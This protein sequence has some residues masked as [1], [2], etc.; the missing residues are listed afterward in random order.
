MSPNDHLLFNSPIVGYAHHQIVVSDAGVPCDYAFIEVNA[1]FEK[2]TGI[3]RDN[4]IGR[5]AREVIPGIEH[6]A[7]DWIAYYGAIALN[8]GEK[9]FEQYCEHLERWYRV[10][11]YS[12]E[13]NCFTTVF[14]DITESRLQFE[15]LEAFFSVNLDLLCI[16]DLDG[17]FIKTNT[18]WTRIL[19]YSTEELNRRKFLEFVHPDDIQATLDVMATLGQG[20]DVLDF[21]NRYRSSDGS[22]RYIQW[23]SHP[24]GNLVYAAARDITGSKQLEEAARDA[25]LRFSLAAKAGNVGVWDYDVAGNHLLWDEQMYALYGITS[26]TFSGVYE[27]WRSGLHPEDI[28]RGDREITMALKGEREFNTEFRV[29]WPDGSIHHIRALATVIRDPQGNAIRMVGTNWDI[30]Q[31]KTN[32][33]ALKRAKEEAETANKAK[34]VFLANM[35]HEIRTPLNSVIGFTDLLRKTAL[36]PMQ[37]QYADNANVSGRALLDIINDILDFS[38]IEAG[39]L[40]LELIRTDMVELLRNSINIVKLSA[41]QKQLDVLLDID[42]AMPQFA[43]VDPV[44]LRQILTNLL[45]NAVKFTERGSVELKVV[46][47]PVG[48]GRTHFQFFV[49][50]TGIGI[51]HEQKEKLFKSF[52]QADNSTTRR[53]GGTGLG[54]VISDM[55]AQRMG[56]RIHVESIPR[57]G[58]TFYFDLATASEHGTPYN[59]EGFVEIDGKASSLRE[60]DACQGLTILIAEDVPM[61]RVLAKSMILGLFPEA[62]LVEAENGHAAL[63]QY[64]KQP[65][66]VILMDVQ[67]P[68]MDG[69]EATRAIRIL[70]AETG[71]HVPIIALTAGVFREEQEQCTASGMDFFLTKPIESEKLREALIRV[72]SAKNS[73]SATVHFNRERLRTR[74]DRETADVIATYLLTDIPSYIEAIGSAIAQSDIAE[75]RRRVHRLKGSSLNGELPVIAAISKEMESNAADDGDLAF[76]KGRFEALTEAWSHAK[77]ELAREGV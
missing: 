6:A 7:F 8:G 45:S 58:S 11:V 28:E 63:E 33:E 74:C 16:A 31:Q 53:F 24:K 10:H 71:K 46:C 9:E 60:I 15:E 38:K 4:L 51:T 75:V 13:K 56:S 57:E 26:E 70:E 30:T 35:S 5:T 27:A 72:H 23:R 29:V 61:N 19:G 43:V 3:S 39:M 34:S 1:T 47:T 40:N 42:P 50:D 25:T 54:L 52:S 18:A 62:N 64:M 32:E 65:P 76:L 21:T 73:S 48:T 67:M 44:R 2:I 14:I 20:D 69:L 59:P 77:K 12:T 37:Q 55:I 49:Q 17:N 36:S 41:S 66:D 22:Y 68:E